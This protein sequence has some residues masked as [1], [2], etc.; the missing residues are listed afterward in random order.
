[1]NAQLD[2]IIQDARDLRDAIMRGGVAADPDCARL[3]DH[4]MT[5][6][7]LVAELAELAKR[8]S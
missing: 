1:M 3:Q 8:A 6:A 2:R 4:V 5:L 7:S